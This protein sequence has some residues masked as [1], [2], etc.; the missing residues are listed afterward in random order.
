[1]HAQSPILSFMTDRK[2]AM[3]D[4][5]QKTLPSEGTFFHK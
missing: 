2:T 3:S 4:I 1:M 5:I